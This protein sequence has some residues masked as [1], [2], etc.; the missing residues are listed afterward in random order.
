MSTKYDTYF[1]ITMK[2]YSKY[3][4]GISSATEKKNLNFYRRYFVI[5]AKR[6]KKNITYPI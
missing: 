2:L 4:V 3:A 5:K 6:R 1:R